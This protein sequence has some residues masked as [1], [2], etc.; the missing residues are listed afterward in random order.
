MPPEPRQCRECHAEV[1]SDAR[2]CAACGAKLAAVCPA[3]DGVLPDD[4]NRCPRC[5]RAVDAQPS[6]AVPGAAG[7]VES[8]RRPIVVLMADISG[9]SEISETMEV[10]WLYEVLNDT[11]GELSECVLA[12]G[13]RIDKYVGD[14]IVA[15]FGFPRTFEDAADRAVLAAVSMR[16]RM[17]AISSRNISLVGRALD[18]HIG[19]NAGTVMAGRV[20][21]QD[22]TSHTV[23]G[24]A[25]NIAKRLESEAPAGE[26]YVSDSVRTRLR[27][28][29]DLEPLG[30]L[31]IHGRGE[32]VESYRVATTQKPA[33]APL[34]RVAEEWLARPQL[35]DE[36]QAAADG[37]GAASSVP[38]ALLVGDIGVGKTTLARAM[39]SRWRKLGHAVVE[40]TCTSVTAEMPYWAVADLLWGLAYASGPGEVEDDR[41]ADQRLAT[42]LAADREARDAAREVV[43]LRRRSLAPRQGVEP[44]ALMRALAALLAHVCE[45]R[46]LAVLFDN[47]Q[48]I[49]EAD[50][51]VLES[52]RPALA[53]LPAAFWI[54]SARSQEQVP[55]ASSWQP[56]P[57][58]VPPLTERQ[59]AKLLDRF[60]GAS[61]WS[62]SVKR[63]VLR[64]A[65]GNPLHLR[66]LAAW[67][68]REGREDP[69]AGSSGPPILTVHELV[70]NRVESLAS[71]L[72]LLLQACAVVGEPIVPSLVRQLVS[73]DVCSP[74]RL[75]ELL[76]RKYLEA[77]ARPGEFRFADRLA[78]EVTYDVI[79]LQRRRELHGRLADYLAL[80]GAEEAN[81]HLLARH[82][83]LGGWGVQAIPHLVASA[84]AYSAEYANRDCLRVA[85]RALEA[86]SSAADPRSWY[87]ERVDT[88]LL[89]ARSW[90]VLGEP[91]NA[92]MALGEAM[93]LAEELGDRALCA[94]VLLDS[95][96]N[97][98]LR[99]DVARAVAAY[100]MSAER[101]RELGDETRWAQ[102]ILGVGMGQLDQGDLDAALTSF[103][104][105]AGAAG[106]EGWMR[107]AALNNI[108]V[109]QMRRGELDHAERNL[110][111]A[112]ELN[113]QEGDRR[114]EAYCLTSLGELSLDRGDPKVA[115][116]FLQPAIDAAREIEDP[117]AIFTAGTSLARCRVLCGDVTG[118]R[119]VVDEI[120]PHIDAVTDRVVLQRFDG[121]RAHLEPALSMGVAVGR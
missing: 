86:M 2:F 24:D 69:G 102:C 48:W 109:I 111:E 28:R 99:R 78:A 36:L 76:E 115:A 23:I 92:A 97:A 53:T 42:V 64:E 62:H 47:A 57:V 74:S 58:F 15:L 107:S 104:A 10:D 29:I 77:A 11:L 66:E 117:Q 25:V 45:R 88:L 81:V 119:A 59:S 116:E 50:L 56:A 8:Q 49:G 34:E 67:L 90:H 3:C 52:L 96:Y 30:P 21:H 73:D 14:E 6:P 1:A 75:T 32:P 61:D 31:R 44:Q 118:A 9:Y 71:P 106:A 13:G 68:G 94:M 87:S 80:R 38:A 19:I 20:G 63:S 100:A 12:H 46:R 43:A 54:L 89:M 26:I 105:A 5:D 114:G 55:L 121:L 98:L 65:K 27:G 113:R 79:P 103:Q 84:R 93:V 83:C 39:L 85:E 16:D 108:G 101:W 91:E 22:A 17:S 37:G 4:A 35:L 82:A 70:L 95:A 18:I 120:L 41:S 110:R 40:T 51:A 33:P 7:L 72:P 112:L 60:P